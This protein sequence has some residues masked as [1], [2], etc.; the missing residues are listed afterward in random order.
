MLPFPL[1]YFWTWRLEGAGDETRTRDNLLGRQVLYQLSYP[2]AALQECTPLAL[3]WARCMPATAANNS[4]HSLPNLP[5]LSGGY[6]TCVYGR[7]D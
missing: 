2:R 1:L 7:C 3:G 4:D 6:D 5:S